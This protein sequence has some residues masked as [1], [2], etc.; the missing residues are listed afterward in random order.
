MP[1]DVTARLTSEKLRIEWLPGNT[2]EAIHDENLALDS[3]VDGGTFKLW[4]LGEETAAISSVSL[5]S[6]SGNVFTTTF[7][8][9]Q[10]DDVS[11]GLLAGDKIV[12]ETSGGDLPSGVIIDQVYFVINPN[13]NDFQVSL[14][15]GGSAV[16]LSDD[17]TGTHHWEYQGTAIAENMQTAVDALANMTAG[18]LAITG[19]LITALNMIGTQI[20]NKFFRILV[21]DDSLT[22][23]IANVNDNTTLTVTVQGAAYVVLSA[24]ASAFSWERSVETVDVTALSEY[25]RIEIPVA[26]SVSF[27]LSL[28]K[29]EAGTEVWVY[30]VYPGNNGVFWVFP[31]GK[32]IGKENFKFKALFADAGEDFPDHEKVEI[33]LSGSRQGAWIVQ[34]NS[35]YRGT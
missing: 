35:I 21:T 20:G 4:V 25:D 33:E 9:D 13:A 15:V 23:S 22:K 5:A 2:V 17:G 29:V 27:D 7:G 19:T 32:I 34:P 26:E 6:G 28:Y 8:S 3:A 31:E 30:S 12:L 18:D 11:H 1:I 14:L 10:F 24:Q 16:A